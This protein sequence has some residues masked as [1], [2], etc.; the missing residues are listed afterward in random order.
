M[1]YQLLSAF[2]SPV[3]LPLL[4]T[5]NN[6]LFLLFSAYFNGMDHIYTNPLIVLSMKATLASIRQLY[7]ICSLIRS[8]TLSQKN[9]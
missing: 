1:N 8:L 7:K 5:E 2:L 6:N 9:K 3:L 4:N